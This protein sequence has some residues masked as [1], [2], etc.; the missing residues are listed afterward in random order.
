MTNCN[1]V[2]N[3]LLK[4]YNRQYFTNYSKTNLFSIKEDVK[5]GELIALLN[6]R[7][8]FINDEIFEIIEDLYE[9]RYYNGTLTCISKLGKQL[10]TELK[11]LSSVVSAG[12]SFPS[13]EIKEELENILVKLSE[14]SCAVGGC[15][16]DTLL[17]K[18]PK[19][20]D[21]VTDADYDVMS[22]TFTSRGWTVKETGKQ[23][24][25]MIVNKDGQDFEIA[26]FRKDNT[27][28]DGRRPSSTDIGTIEEDAQR[29]DFTINS[30]Y[31][32]LKEKQLIDPTGQ[33]I[34]DLKTKTLRFIGSA[35]ERIEQDYLRVFRFYRFLKTKGLKAHPGSLRTVRT[36]FAEAVSKTDPERIRVEIERM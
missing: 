17:E 11:E 9:L 25:V 32:S 5:S 33:G 12:L 15:V 16:R 23:F 1:Y 4:E 28:V 27:Y 3:K 8:T 19:D 24:R 22:S 29:R 30:L 18:T 2:F 10:Q 21:Y 36:M 6:V 26:N 34:E 14:N 7:D 31:F 20:F 35:E 13:T